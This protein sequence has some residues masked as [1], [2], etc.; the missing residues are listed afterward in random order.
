MF[1]EKR[2]APEINDVVTLKLMSGEEVI[3]KLTDR[4]MD[5]VFLT[6][7]VQIVMQPI[8]TNQLGLAFQPILGSVHDAVMQFPFSGMAIRPVKTGEEVT[9]NYIQ[10]TTGLLTAKADSLLT[11]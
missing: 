11:A 1:I 2:S 4:T 7:P 8:A 5:S 10:A 3:G 6:K 9:R